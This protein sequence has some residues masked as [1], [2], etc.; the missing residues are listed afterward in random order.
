MEG[1]LNFP[2]LILDFSEPFTFRSALMRHRKLKQSQTPK[3]LWLPQTQ[4]MECLRHRSIWGI[5]T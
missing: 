3:A 1:E 5:D 2:F 4:A